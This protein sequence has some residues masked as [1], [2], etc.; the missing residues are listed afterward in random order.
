MLLVVGDVSAAHDIGGL[1]LARRATCPLAIVVVDNGGGR[2]F[3]Q[4]PIAAA[5]SIAPDFSR[6][7]LTPPGIDFA[8]AA[9][10]YGVD[11][12]ATSNYGELTTA[13]RAALGRPGCT[14]IR[15]E[16]AA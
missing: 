13:V 11:Y 16:V 15:A 1:A 5:E 6:L 2:I 10:T 8:A 7:W 4:L 14:L 9:A 12:A 3:E